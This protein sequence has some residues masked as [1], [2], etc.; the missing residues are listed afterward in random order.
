M[1]R[2][3]STLRLEKSIV[4][5]IPRLPTI[6]VIGSQEILRMLLSIERMAPVTGIR[7]RATSERYSGPC[8]RWD[9]SVF[10]ETCVYFRS[11]RIARP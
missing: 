4:V 3:S 1:L 9:G 7:K 11:W 8:R 2:H 10:I 5:W 6:R